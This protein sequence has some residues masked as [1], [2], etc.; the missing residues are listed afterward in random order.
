M[1][2]AIIRLFGDLD[3]EDM[4]VVKN[5]ISRL[6]VDGCGQIVLDFERVQ[7]IN[8][9]GLGILAERQLQVRKRQGDLRVA[10]LNPYLQNVFELTG[11]R[12]AFRTYPSVDA[13][14][15]SFKELVAA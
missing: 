13:A 1:G 14:A 2:V 9:T 11:I 6:L 15:R 4:V 3:M 5:L 12:R 8:A 7:H 10:G